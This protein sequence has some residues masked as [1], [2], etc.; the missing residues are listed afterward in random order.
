MGLCVRDVY[1]LDG[2][3]VVVGFVVWWTRV[4]WEPSCGKPL[5]VGGCCALWVAV[6]VWLPGWLELWVVYALFA[7]FASYLEVVV[8]LVYVVIVRGRGGF[9]RARGHGKWM[10]DLEPEGKVQP[11]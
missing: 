8:E 4:W 1:G 9:P 3:G 10:V 6:V 2:V 5:L 11:W 7:S